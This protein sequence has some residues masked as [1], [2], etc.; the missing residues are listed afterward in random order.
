M[1]VRQ[2][3]LPLFIAAAVPGQDTDW[4]GFR[5]T[6]ASA[7]QAAAVVRSWSESANIVWRRELPGPGTSSPVVVG[8]SVYVTCWSGYGLDL[9]KPGEPSKLR[10]HLL[11]LRADTGEVVWQRT[12]RPVPTEDP[13]GGR[14]ATHGY[15]SSTPVSDG[16]RVYVMFGKSGVFAYDLAGEL[17][18]QR[19]VGT[20]SSEWLTGSGSSLAL[21]QDHLLVNASDESHSVR[22]LDKRTGREIWRRAAAELDQAYGTPLVV[23][24]DEPVMVLALLGSIWALCPRT[25]ERVW[26][27]ATKTNGALGPTVVRGGEAIFSLGGQTH[28]RSHAVRLGGHGDVTGTHLNWH[29]RYGSYVTTPLWHDGHLYWVNEGGIAHCADDATGDLVYK[30]RLDGQFYSSPV[31]AGDCIYYVSRE[32]GTFVVPARPEFEILAHNTIA[33]DESYFDGTPA[34]SGSRMFLRSRRRLYCIAAP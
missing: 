14:M 33:G 5:G 32:N 18:W 27:V 21:W 7:S 6:D 20:G 10:R 2:A 29:T 23:D 3:C 30:E 4:R 26:M 19:S 9:E 11:R 13:F 24:G 17:A 25:G 15:A 34:L 31:R 22:A 12:V 16:E 1:L 28:V 8:D